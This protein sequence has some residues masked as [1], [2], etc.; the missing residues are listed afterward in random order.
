MEMR[1]ADEADIWE[2]KHD[3]GGGALRSQYSGEW[4]AIAAL[5]FP[6]VVLV[7]KRF[8][9]VRGVAGGGLGQAVLPAAEVARSL[10]SCF[11]HFSDGFENVLP[12]DALQLLQIRAL[13]SG[14]GFI[15]LALPGQNTRD[16]L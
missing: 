10:T 11:L 14:H 16:A 6:L 2:R 15:I 4:M 13:Q 8:L 3:A 12:P 5:D 7:L 1:G 9:D